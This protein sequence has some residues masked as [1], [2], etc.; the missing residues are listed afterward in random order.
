MKNLLN[1]GKALNKAEQKNVVG[2]FGI[3]FGYGT[4]TRDS[5]C[6]QK[7]PNEH[8]WPVYHQGTCID[9]ICDFSPYKD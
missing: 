4:C 6:Y 1:L 5:E 2:G 9:G 7:I 3:G 8:G